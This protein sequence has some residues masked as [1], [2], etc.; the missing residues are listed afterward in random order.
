MRM[1]VRIG[2]H[3]Q[4]AAIWPRDR[5]PAIGLAGAMLSL[6]SC[7]FSQTPGTSAGSGAVSSGQVTVTTG[8]PQYAP[9]NTVDVTIANG[10]S[11]GIL[12]ADHQSD[13]T[14]LVIEHL[15]GQTWQP[16]N[17]CLLKSPTRL[18]P[19]GAGTSTQQT[20]Q[21]PSGQTTAGW[22]TGSYRISLTYRQT[23]GGPETTVYSAQFTIA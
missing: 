13:C 7:G 2:R 22:P 19:F 14:V 17:P 21:P 23:P 11:S 3:H 12:A 15:S 18:I 6:A 16:Q 1:S 20:L 8:K 9:T 5:W 4:P 10:L